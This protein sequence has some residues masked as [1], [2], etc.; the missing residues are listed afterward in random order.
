MAT[1]PIHRIQGQVMPVNSFVIRGPDGIIV[2]D[3]LVDAIT[4]NA[5]TVADGDH[6]PVLKAMPRLDELPGLVPDLPG[7]PGARSA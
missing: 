2:V 4:A 6:T 5:E 3:G 7:A 1:Y